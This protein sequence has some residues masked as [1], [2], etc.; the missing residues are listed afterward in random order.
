MGGSA[1]LSDK[2]V[3]VT[4]ASRGIGYAVSLAAAHAGANVIITGRTIGALEELDDHVLAQVEQ[5][6]AHR[7]HVVG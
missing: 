7:R 6:D 3:L 5:V 4:G 1:D 2:V